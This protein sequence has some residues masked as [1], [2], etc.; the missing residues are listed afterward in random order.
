GSFVYPKTVP[1]ARKAI[2]GNTYPVKDQLKALG[3][4]WSPDQH[5]W[6]VPADKA[7]QARALVG[8]G[9]IPP[10]SQKQPVSEDQL[11]KPGLSSS[12]DTEQHPY[13]T[14]EG[15]I[16]PMLAAFTTRRGDATAA[17]TGVERQGIR[18]GDRI[19][20]RYLDDTDNKT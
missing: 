7:N 12:A 8:T 6:M 3:G 16:S 4:R 15:G 19:V 5:A 9:K 10:P 14:M 1:Q 18:T 11:D 13:R 17:T 20:I 2:I